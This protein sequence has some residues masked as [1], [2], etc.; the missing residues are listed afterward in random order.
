MGLLVSPS[1]LQYP[2]A[3][4]EVTSSRALLDRRGGL[5]PRR[6]RRKPPPRARV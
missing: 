2:G 4:R 3:R 5:G 6:A 1:N